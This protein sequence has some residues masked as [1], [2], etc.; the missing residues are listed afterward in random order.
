M[1]SSSFLIA[2][3]CPFLGDA[4]RRSTASDGSVSA[5]GGTTARSCLPPPRVERSLL[6]VTMLP[7]ASLSVRIAMMMVRSLSS[8]MVL[9]PSGMGQLYPGFSNQAL[10]VRWS[11]SYLL[12]TIDEKLY[13]SSSELSVNPSRYSFSH[14]SVPPSSDSLYPDEKD[15]TPPGASTLLPRMS[16]R[17]TQLRKP[18]AAPLHTP[19]AAADTAISIS[20]DCAFLR[21]VYAV[22]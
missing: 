8:R 13:A 5:T 3:R 15:F 12:R 21:T 18:S 2:G 7:S 17:I 22:P 20:P 9:P 11:S 10:L 4:I 19:C 1:W 16:C 6:D 14:S